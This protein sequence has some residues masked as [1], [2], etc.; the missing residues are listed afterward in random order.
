M[1]NIKDIFFKIKSRLGSLIKNK[2][3]NKEQSVSNLLDGDL[4]EGGITGNESEA[5][6]SQTG[7]TKIVDEEDT[8]VMEGKS[9]EES[10]ASLL[11][12]NG[13]KDL[14]GLSWP[15]INIVTSVG[16][17]RRLN[18]IIISHNSLSKTH[19]QIIKESG[20]FYLVDLKSTN[21]TYLNDNVVEPYKKI[22]LENNSY[23]RA[24]YLIFKFLDKGNIESFSSMKILKKA[25]TD[26]LTGA[27]N[28]RLLKI[29]GPE[30]FF[31]NQKLSLIVFDIDNFKVINDSFGHTAGDYILKALSK[32]M[33]DIIREGD[34]FIRY[35][36]DEFCI[37]TPNSLSVAKS[38]SYRI[39]QKLQTNQFV[40]KDQRISLD[41][42]I[43]VAEKS[44][45][46][47]TWEDIY[48]RADE[49]S[50]E[51]KRR[52]KAVQSPKNF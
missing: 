32:H 18:D 15:L 27:G 14:I 48:H 4:S 50:Y 45:S 36:G 33:L 46:D 23:V 3:G 17:S 42:S 2:A 5:V 44:P 16:R 41:I 8:L 34:L 19:F 24:S 10:P 31:S 9:V 29:K 40:F 20:K 7:A 49:Q 51:Q 37:F 11:L 25:Q 35:G 38:I 22:A 1:K 21:K 43:G 39:K 12:L 13:P 52:K 47:K 28:R 26:S 30:Y 6:Y